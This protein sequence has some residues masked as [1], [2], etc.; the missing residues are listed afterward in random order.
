MNVDAMMTAECDH[1]IRFETCHLLITF[2]LQHHPINP[3][4]VARSIL[5]Q[6]KIKMGILFV[7]LKASMVGS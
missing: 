7:L 3:H 1:V 4:T 6:K 5:R 2:F